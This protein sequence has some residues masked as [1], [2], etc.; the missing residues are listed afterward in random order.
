MLCIL[1][2]PAFAV[3][4]ACY[5]WLNGTQN[6]T[7]I[8]TDLID[9]PINLMFGADVNLPHMNGLLNGSILSYAC[10]TPSDPVDCSYDIPPHVQPFST[11]ADFTLGH[12][13]YN[14]TTEGIGNS[15]LQ[16]CSTSHMLSILSPPAPPTPPTATIGSLISDVGSGLGAF[17]DSL[18]SPLA[19]LLL[20]FGLIAGVLS[21]FYALAWV[22]KNKIG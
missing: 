19:M 8:V 4:T 20:L 7:T 21:I 2:T 3:T 9:V 16:N 22:V 11:K 14:I 12:G 6:D 5:L 15:S 1:V 17:L 10:G 18:G 13:V